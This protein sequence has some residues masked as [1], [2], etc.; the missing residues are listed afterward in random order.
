MGGTVEF[1]VQQQRL[2]Y[3]IGVLHNR[4]LR[5]G[6][7]PSLELSPPA[8]MSTSVPVEGEEEE[9]EEEEEEMD[10]EPSHLVFVVHGIGEKMW[11]SDAV[12]VRSFW[13]AVVVV[14]VCV[15]LSVGVV[16]GWGICGRDTPSRCVFVGVVSVLF[17]WGGGWGFCGR[18]GV[19]PPHAL[20]AR[21]H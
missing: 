16:E 12:Q 13:P 20:P 3:G 10:R 6:I 4:I 21:G 5:R 15:V 1:E 9:E 19:P 11:Q 18:G 2:A 8:P 17:P 14:W 7:D